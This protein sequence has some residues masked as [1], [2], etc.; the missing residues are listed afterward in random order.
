MTSADLYAFPQVTPLAATTAD[1]DAALERLWREHGPVAPV[2]LM[3]GVRAWLVMGYAEIRQ[4]TTQDHLFSRNADSWSLVQ[5]GTV[6]P[7]SPLGPMMFHRDNVIGADGEEHRRLRRPIEQA[8]A[9]LD[10]RALRRTVERLSA[11]LIDRIAPSGRA[12]LIAD[13]AASIPLLAIGEL[14]GL[15][16]GRARELLEAMNLLFSSG[17]R[18]QEG[19]AKFEALLNE[20]VTSRTNL[21]DTGPGASGTSGSE[22]RPDASGTSGSETGAGGAADDLT[23][24]LVG[25]EDLGTTS[26]ILQT[27]VVVVSAANHTSISWIAETLR[28]ML[29]DPRFAGRINGGRLSI[30]DALD[31]VLAR[32]PPMINFPARYPLAD[33]VLADRPVRRGDALILGLAASARDTRVHASDWWTRGSRAH[34]AW[35]V[36][37]HACPGRDPARTI[38]R[39][40]V[41]TAQHL[42]GGLRLACDPAEIR[43]QPSPWIRTPISLP[44]TFHPHAPAAVSRTTALEQP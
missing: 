5:D 32:Q 9:G 33:T 10:H 16:P 3:P 28:L 29:V 39:T 41:A 11:E 7:D 6:G 14:I 35:S 24:F 21:P 37:P 15:D 19:N 34:L 12:D 1:P 4:I 25:H 38:A 26:E 42:L 18:A 40:A 27:L 36:G 44:V 20:L 22:P 30:D 17:P 2:E 43:Y 13:Y 31:E 23:G 8:L